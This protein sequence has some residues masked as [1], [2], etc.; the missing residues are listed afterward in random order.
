MFLNHGQQFER[1][2]ARPLRAG[3]HKVERM[4]RTPVARRMLV[5]SGE[6]GYARVGVELVGVRD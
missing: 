5:F 4:L 3:M 6:G 2:T 1:H